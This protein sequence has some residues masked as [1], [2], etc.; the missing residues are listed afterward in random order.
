MSAL[1]VKSLIKAIVPLASG[2]SY[3]L[4]SVMFIYDKRATALTLLENT[5]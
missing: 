3:F 4:L 2:N 5:V 1:V